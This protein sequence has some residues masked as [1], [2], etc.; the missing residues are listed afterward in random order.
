[1]TT[2]YMEVPAHVQHVDHVSNQ[3]NV[4]GGTNW[5][6]SRSAVATPITQLAEPVRLV[7]D[8]PS[9]YRIRAG[10]PG[11]ATKTIQFSLNSVVVPANAQKLLKQVRSGVHVIVA[12][13]AD[14]GEKNPETLA[15]KRVAEIAARLRKQGV[16]VDSVHSFGSDHSADVGTAAA[17]RRVEIYV[18]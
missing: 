4:K 15:T 3:V 1:M 17:N 10:L 9:N 16:K 6:L 2:Y 13:H 12:G 8:V 18:K 14:D 5:D 11:D 7:P